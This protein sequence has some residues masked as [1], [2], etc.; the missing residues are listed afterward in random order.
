MKVF[1]L[2]CDHDHGFE[3][4]FASGEEYDSQIAR[5]LVECPICGSKDIRKLPSA[6]RLNLTSTESA[7]ATHVAPS[8]AQVQ[9]MWMQMARRIVEHT[10]DVGDRFAEEARK[11]HYRESPERGIRGVASPDEAAQLREEGIE[12]FSFPMPKVAK[13]PLQ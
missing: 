12:V 9:Q 5:G 7:K 3:G 10:D 2:S 6:P 11:I 1:N 8:P 4:W 13:E